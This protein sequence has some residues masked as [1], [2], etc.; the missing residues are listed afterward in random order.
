MFIYTNDSTVMGQM[1]VMLP[2][3]DLVL[4]LKYGRNLGQVK[5]IDRLSNSLTGYIPREITSLLGDISS[6]QQQHW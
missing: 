2:T 6:S 4:E 5:A 1:L 3:M